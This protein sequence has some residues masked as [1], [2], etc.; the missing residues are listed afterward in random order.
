[1]RTGAR[2]G[3]GAR[4]RRGRPGTIAAEAAGARGRGAAGPG[5]VPAAPSAPAPPVGPRAPSSRGSSA[6][7]GRGRW[8]GRRVASSET[9]GR[10]SGRR[11]LVGPLLPGCV[12]RR[13]GPA[14]SAPV[15]G[16]RRVP[17]AH[18]DSVL[19]LG[20]FFVLM[21]RANAGGGA[22]RGWSGLQLPPWRKSW[23]SRLGQE[24]E[25]SVRLSA[26]FS[27]QRALLWRLTRRRPFD[28]F[29]PPSLLFVLRLCSLSF[30]GS[31]VSSKVLW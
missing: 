6:H 24:V 21:F 15:A 9:L 8:S 30:D 22:E 13:Q 27:G 17:G 11:R 2:G 4:G 12:S 31:Q 7:V 28:F 20:G 19:F 3:R 16:S 26:S 10:R 14:K 18:G 25:V 5:R 1:M 23:G 29:T